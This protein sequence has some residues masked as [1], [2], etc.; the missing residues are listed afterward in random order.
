MQKST[1]KERYEK[2]LSEENKLSALQNQYENEIS[3]LSNE[4]E[5]K[6]KKIDE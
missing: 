2:I 4:I 1:V 3:K 5:E 6:S